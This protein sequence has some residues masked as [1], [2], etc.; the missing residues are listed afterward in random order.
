MADDDDGARMRERGRARFVRR[1]P[2][3]VGGTLVGLMVSAALLRLVPPRYDA[4]ATLL[5]DEAPRIASDVAPSPDVEAKA[6]SRVSPVLAREAVERLGQAASPEHGG[7]AGADRFLASL[8]V[9]SAT[10]SRAVTIAFSSRNPV[11]AA[12]GANAFADVAAQSLNEAR[13]RAI[14]AAEE[15]LERAVGEDSARLAEAEAR[16]ETEQVKAA[17]PSDAVPPSGPPDTGDLDA[18]LAAAHVVEAAASEK[19]ALLRRFERGGLADVPASSADEPL[20][21]LL[22]RRAALEAEIADASKT[23]LPL[24]PRMKNLAAEL[25]ALDG[26]IRGA[27]D[28][29]ASA[30]EADARQARDTASAL[31]AERAARSTAAAAASDARAALSPLEAEVEAAR[32]ALASADEAAREAE[33]GFASDNEA[34]EA[35]VLVAAAP[36]REVAFP[37]LWPT[38]AAGAGVGCLLSGLAA[39]IAPRRRPAPP[40]VAPAV[41]DFAADSRAQP[42]VAHDPF[43][44]PEPA[45]ATPAP[46]ALDAPAILVATLRRLK[47]K[48]GLVVLVAGDRSGQALAVAL[49][50]ARRFARERAAVLI[51]LGESQDWLSDILY[52][53]RPDDFAA[54]GLA[55]LVASDAGF[56]EAIGRDLSSTLDVVLAGSGRAEGRIDEALI[57]FAAAYE[58]VVLHASDW[59]SAWPRAAAVFA[60]AVVVV[61]PAARSGSA[62]DAAAAGI[63]DACPTV[64][65]Y[66]VRAGERALDRAA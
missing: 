58:A 9:R 51:D 39:A 10:G 36:P 49:E 35:K 33:A 29:A 54:P 5:L 62:R 27:A 66:A 1:W 42:A 63:G 31:A 47:P 23:F 19:A 18:K 24:H 14:R 32:S 21:R 60:D 11:L 61:A 25:A 48:G 45:L 65:A 13:A 55:E 12:E 37:A 16:L 64:L 46:G 57:A 20:R 59:R 8:S 7:D 44:P 6:L 40:A 26:E 15:R 52:R 56:G 4:A 28:R 22:E 38:L 53:E 41:Q 2:W 3:P 43:Q 17:Q 30:S 50:T 34:G